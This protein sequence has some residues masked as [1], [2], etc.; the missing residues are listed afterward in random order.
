[1]LAQDAFNSACQMLCDKYKKYGFKFVKSKRLIKG[2]IGEAEIHIEIETSRDN[3]SD[4]FVYF[5]PDARLYIAGKAVFWVG[6]PKREEA[7]LLF[8]D[9][10]IVD[11][12]DRNAIT[13]TIETRMWIG[14]LFHC[15][16]VAYPEQQKKAAEEAA[17]WLDKYFFGNEQVIG[18]IGCKVTSVTH[19]Y[20]EEN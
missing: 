2:I 15:W 14:S 17:L 12:S 1:M 9:N 10:L 3:S 20:E 7:E 18:L 19:I 13:D 8:G 11:I 4:Y 6:F 5:K 16:N